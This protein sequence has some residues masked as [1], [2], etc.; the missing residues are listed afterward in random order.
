MKKIENGRVVWIDIVKIVACF[1]VIVNHFT[2]YYLN[3][4]SNSL[5]LIEKFFYIFQ[6]CFSRT[7]VPLF[8]M[9]TGMLM[10][11]KTY[12]FKDCF[13]KIV[14][15]LILL[16]S[17]TILIII[18][19]PLEFQNYSLKTFFEE[20]ILVTYWYLYI[21]IGL[22][23]LIPI[24][25]KMLKNLKKYDCIYIFIICFVIPGIIQYINVALEMNV[26]S[27]FTSFFFSTLLVYY[28]IGTVVPKIEKNK[29]NRNIAWALFLFSSYIYLLTFMYFYFKNGSIHFL[30]L[31]CSNVFTGIMAFSSFYLFKY[32]FEDK[33]I[34]YKNIISNISLTTFGIYIFHILILNKVSNLLMA[35]KLNSIIFALITEL[36]IFFICSFATYLLRKIPILKKIL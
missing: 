29:K 5:L 2:E 18:I 25:Q 14:R 28:I 3:T 6:L 9:I 12:T 35:C 10:S 31:D 17:I 16:V 30:Y 34:K 11:R 4:Y 32:Y 21:L 33:K 26:S 36:M 8:L 1:S 24:L 15:I 13:Y 20:P 27:L 7:A 23:L 22:Y 19:K